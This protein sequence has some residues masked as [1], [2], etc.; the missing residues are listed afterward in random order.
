MNET[1]KIFLY[2]VASGIVFIAITIICTI[3]FRKNRRTTDSDARAGIEQ[4]RATCESAGKTST[5]LAGT[6]EQTIRIEQ[7]LAG[8][9]EQLTDS[10]ARSKR[11]LQEIKKRHAER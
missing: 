2:G 10:I 9:N 3:F 6:T 5:E 8:T 4:A 1:I 11:I 7:D